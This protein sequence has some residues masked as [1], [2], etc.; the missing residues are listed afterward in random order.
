MP[1]VSP[2]GIFHDHSTST[3]LQDL[4]PAGQPTEF[5]PL[6]ACRGYL[7]DV[8]GY[9]NHSR[10]RRALRTEIPEYELR[11]YL[12]NA[13]IAQTRSMILLADLYTDQPLRYLPT[14]SGPSWSNSVMAGYPSAYVIDDAA[15]RLLSTRNTPKPR[16]YQ[17][18]NSKWT[19]LL[20]CSYSI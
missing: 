20:L 5:Y 12:Q 3:A 14:V 10:E 15:L 1:P 11:E 8:I 7:C 17:M 2:G 19:C 16:P 4:R 6:P 18:G 9:V 13:T